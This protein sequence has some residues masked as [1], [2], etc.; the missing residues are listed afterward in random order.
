M[1][2]STKYS[3][4]C[5]GLASTP[6]PPTKRRP[7]SIYGHKVTTIVLQ[8]ASPRKMEQLSLSVPG[9]DGR[10]V[11]SGKN[12][13]KAHQ[14]RKELR[15]W[16][17]PKQKRRASSTS[18]FTTQ[19]LKVARSGTDVG[20]TLV[21]WLLSRSSYEIPDFLQLCKTTSWSLAALPRWLFFGSLHSK[22]ARSGNAFQR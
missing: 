4:F 6:P 21:T 22:R 7:N 12:G 13:K 14:V 1:R 16:G 10:N 18:R 15:P 20:S 2:C 11:H 19:S 17:V 9:G 3:P 5:L 8:S